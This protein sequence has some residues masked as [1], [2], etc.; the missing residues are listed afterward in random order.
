[1]CLSPQVYFAYF[2]HTEALHLKYFL[3]SISNIL[4]LSTLCECSTTQPHPWSCLVYLERVLGVSSG[5]L[6]IS[7]SFK[8]LVFFQHTH[9][10]SLCPLSK[11]SYHC[12]LP[13]WQAAARS[14]FRKC[15]F[16][17]RVLVCICH[18]CPVFLPSHR[19]APVAVFCS[20]ASTLI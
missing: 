8:F 17:C 15:Y 20:L 6:N 7:P 12:F 19:L 16:K 9:N 18:T 5:A 14:P 10:L 2:K 4:V 11:G 1:M 13:A 3:G